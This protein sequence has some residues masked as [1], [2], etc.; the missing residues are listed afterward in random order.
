MDTSEM[1][2]MLN[3]VADFYRP[4]PRDEAVTGVAEH[5]VSF[6]EPRMRKKLREMLDTGGEGLSEIALAG[7]KE[8]IK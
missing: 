8:T 2:R 1:V 3:Q 4:Y 6:W 7:A 5:I